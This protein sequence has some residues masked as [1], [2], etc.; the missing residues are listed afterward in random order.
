MGDITI[1][2]VLGAGGIIVGLAVL[3]WKLW[4]GFKKAVT[5]AVADQF[6][7]LSKAIN[8][9]NDQLKK[10][11]MEACKN[12]LVRCI[13]DFENDQ[14]INETEVQRFWEQYDHYTAEGHNGYIMHK[15]SLLEKEG[16]IKRKQ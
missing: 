4:D 12:F 1:E 8:D 16:R 11:D 14:P 6:K 3:G 2:Q 10:V 7:N 9:I 5:N 15:V 13:S